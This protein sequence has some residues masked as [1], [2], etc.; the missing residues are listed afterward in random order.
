ME[1]IIALFLAG[2]SF[3][4]AENTNLENTDII[5]GSGATTIQSI[6]DSK[7]EASVS[8]QKYSHELEIKKTRRM[9]GRI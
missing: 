7:E 4:N 1:T 9:A 8:E 2:T 3:F 5:L 6:N